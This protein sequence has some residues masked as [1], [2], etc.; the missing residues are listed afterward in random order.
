[1]LSNI[2]V[3]W[4]AEHLIGISTAISTQ[5]LWAMLVS[6]DKQFYAQCVSFHILVNVRQAYR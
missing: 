2:M 1:M 5:N 3:H 6:D 4:D